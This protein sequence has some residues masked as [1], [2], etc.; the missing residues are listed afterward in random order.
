MSSI[1]DDIRILLVRELR[2]MAREIDLFPDEE[3][4]WVTPPGIVNSAG[5]LVLHGSGNLQHY[6]GAVL[7]KTGYVRD[8]DAEFNDRSASREELL[9]I[10]AET[11]RVMDTVIPA[12]S[13][14]LLDQPFEQ[15]VGGVTLNTR[16]FLMHLCSHLAFHV[17]QIGYLRRIITGDATSSGAVSVKPLVD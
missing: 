8:R 7:G 9:Q 13:P 6:V 4:I 14:D 1:L 2:S 11:V 3:A 17:G 16:R 10:V 15:P 5:S 12:L